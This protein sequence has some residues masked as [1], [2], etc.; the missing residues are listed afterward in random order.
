MRALAR[1]L[2][3]WA[4]APAAA[5]AAPARRPQSPP[6]PGAGRIHLGSGRVHLDGWLNVDMQALPG[7]DYVLDATEGLP[8]RDVEALFAEHFL[9]HLHLADAVEFLLDVHRILRPGGVLRLSTPNLEWVWATHHPGAGA[10]PELQALSA[11][12]I[13]RGFHGWG[14][15]FLWNRALLGRALAACGFTD[16]RWH[17]HGE[18]DRALFRALERHETYADAPDLPHVL[19]VEATKGEPA[20]AALAELRGLLQREFLDHLHG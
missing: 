15:H 20:P 5:A 6:P 8:F 12:H 17:R 19:V 7:V 1:R 9:E 10:D 4:G 2:D 11:L 18:S 16:L 13:N 3:R 14:H